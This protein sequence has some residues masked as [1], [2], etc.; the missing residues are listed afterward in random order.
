MKISLVKQG[1]CLYPYGEAD[2]EALEKMNSAVYVAEV[3]DMDLRTLQQ[4]RALHKLF[5]LISD[6]LKESGQDIKTVIKADVPWTPDHVKELMWRPVMKMITGK[7]ST[8]K[9][10]KQEIDEVYD[11]LNRALGE[12]CGIHVPFPSI[13]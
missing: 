12:R 9:M 5:S 10:T 1:Q 6:A 8:T 3:R 4:N 2:R 11:V 13:N 7:D